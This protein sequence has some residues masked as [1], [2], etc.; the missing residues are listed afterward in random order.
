MNVPVRRG[1]DLGSPES[2]LLG[3]NGGPYVEVPA[4]SRW[5]ADLGSTST[6]LA[7]AKA[8][9]SRGVNYRGLRRFRVEDPNLL[10]ASEVANLNAHRDLIADPAPA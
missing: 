4:V 9:G 7:A 1:S 3:D 8:F 5:I 10:R 2:L 6:R